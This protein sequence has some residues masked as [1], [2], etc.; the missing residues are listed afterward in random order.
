[1]A[2]KALSPEVM[3]LMDKIALNPTSRL[4]VPL[5]EEY[6]KADML[7][8]A[9]FVLVDGIK[10]HP[11]YVAARVML[12][13]IYLQKKQ[14]ADAKVEFEQVIAV[15]PE[16]ILAGKKLAVI[17]QA[18]GELQKAFDACKKILLIDPSDKETKLLLTSLEKDR[19][20][21]SAPVPISSPAVIPAD[22]LPSEEMFQE[23]L[24]SALPPESASEERPSLET[25]PSFA[26]PS[27][28]PEVL[29]SPSLPA[30]EGEDLSPVLPSLDERGLEAAAAGEQNTLSGAADLDEIKIFDGPFLDELPGEEVKGASSTKAAPPPEIELEENPVL[31]DFSEPF[32]MEQLSSALADSAPE[33]APEPEEELAT[34]TLASLYMDQGHF[35][36]A[37]EIYQKI[38]ARDPSNKESLKGLEY[39]LHKLNGPPA[40]H[41]GSFGLENNRGGQSQG[42]TQR[43]QSWLDSIRKDKE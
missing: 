29:I 20:V 19:A 39:A 14:I 12:G 22:P 21:P 33:P 1:M 16:N 7:D 43:L 8:E 15:N 36:E 35:R 4:F 28:E 9:I 11:T 32:A 34:T 25:S 37:A 38:L 2:D 23:S 5:A 42:K 31:S 18:E 6:L 27:S 3:K 13:K 40:L 17:Y 41:P 30:E 10:N 26:I 24:E